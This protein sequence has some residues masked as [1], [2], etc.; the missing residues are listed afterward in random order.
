MVLYNSVLSFSYYELN[1]ETFFNPMHKFIGSGEA[2]VGVL[3]VVEKY[4]LRSCLRSTKK[5]I[6][7]QKDGH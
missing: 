7:R 3:P 1:T 4:V 5:G 2:P 6:H